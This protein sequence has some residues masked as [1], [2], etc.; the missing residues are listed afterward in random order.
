MQATH[1]AVVVR[2]TTAAVVGAA[3]ALAV[4]VSVGLAAEGSSAARADSS[5]PDSGAVSA[6]AAPVSATPVPFDPAAP[7]DSAPPAG[8]GLLPSAP[9]PA[10]VLDSDATTVTVPGYFDTYGALF[11]TVQAQRGTV[12]ELAAQV[13]AAGAVVT[14]RRADLAVATVRLAQATAAADQARGLVDVSARQVYMAGAGGIDG[15]VGVFSSGPT[16]FLANADAWA[17]LGAVTRDNVSAFNSAQAQVQVEQHAVA[18]ATQ[19]ISD[20][21]ATLAVLQQQ[22]ADAMAG[23]QG[24]T[25]QLADLVAS[26]Q[27]QIRIGTDGCPS[28][29]LDGVVPDGLDLHALCVHAI[30]A[31]PTAQAARAVQWALS[32][33]G[34][35]Y[36]CDG[37][38]RLEPFRFDCSSFVSRA[39]FEGAGLHTASDSWAPSTRSMVPWDGLSLDDHYVPIDNDQ[40]R[41]GDLVLYNTCPSD[42]SACAYRHV[43][44]YLGHLVRG[45]PAYMAHTNQ[46]G[47]VA[48]VDQFTGLNDPTLLGV[49]RVLPAPGEHP[50]QG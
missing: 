34:A 45:G 37:I 29:A 14:Q 40:I 21:L 3:C 25:A 5:G 43:V 31:A 8:P 32:R 27:P 24:E 6:S 18:D 11:R 36:A 41:P 30:Q 19:A 44:M 23:V 7:G 22:Y 13:A 17:Y 20:A 39:Y 38:G 48:H 2:T 4:C 47:G 10:P 9:P 12:H 16:S 49:R 15:M 42:G 33:L 50:I 1:N 28:T 46:C 35:P 26:S